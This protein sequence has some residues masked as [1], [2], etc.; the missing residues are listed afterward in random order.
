[1]LAEW[2]AETGP[3]P[4]GEAAEEEVAEAPIVA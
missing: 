4:I 1:M 2:R 3:A